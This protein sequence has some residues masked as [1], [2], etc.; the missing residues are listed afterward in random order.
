MDD[1]TDRA[2]TL[3]ADVVLNVQVLALGALVE[4]R[5]E[6]LRLVEVELFNERRLRQTEG[7]ML[8]SLLAARDA[9]IERLREGGTA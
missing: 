6:R 7:A 5:D 8:R 2:K 9:E 1:S 4:T 3:P